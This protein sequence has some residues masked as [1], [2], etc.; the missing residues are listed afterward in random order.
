MYIISY[1]TV[2]AGS[3]YRWYLLS[4]T[5]KHKSITVIY[6]YNTILQVGTQINTLPEVMLTTAVMAWGKILLLRRLYCVLMRRWGALLIEQR[7]ELW[8]ALL[9][10]HLTVWQRRLM[11]VLGLHETVLTD[12][13]AS[14]WLNT[15]DSQSY[16]WTS[17]H[18]TLS[19]RGRRS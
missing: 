12:W 5:P 4:R 16:S 17:T 9:V 19:S 8:T 15:D 6:T 7:V 1:P 11:L 13:Q 3:G 10:G 18:G 2:I 14:S